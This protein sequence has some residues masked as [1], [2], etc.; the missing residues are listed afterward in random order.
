MN[1]SVGISAQGGDQHVPV[2]PRERRV[3]RGVQVQVQQPEQRRDE[4]LGLPKWQVEE[5][6]QAQRGQDRQVRVARLPAPTPRRRWGPHTEGLFREPD[7]KVAAGAQPALVR[8]PVPHPIPLLVLGVHPAG[9]RR[10]PEPHGPAC[11]AVSH[12]VAGSNPGDVGTSVHSA[13]GACP[14]LP[15]R[16]GLSLHRG[17]PP[18]RSLG[19]PTEWGVNPVADRFPLPGPDAG[20]PYPHL[21]GG[22]G[23]RWRP[24]LRPLAWVRRETQIAGTGRGWEGGVVVSSVTPSLRGAP[25]RR[26]LG[27]APGGHCH[28]GLAR[29]GE[30][31]TTLDRHGRQCIV[32]WIGFNG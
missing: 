14:V 1:R 29:D 24:N 19:E 17:S 11:A 27:A 12:C 2:A 32:R 4:A 9:F 13:E 5:H 8:R 18:E 15:S 30:E 10:G 6:A 28:R 26:C 22:L 31:T 20:K 3:V 7:G 21:V 25:A 23:A 16:E